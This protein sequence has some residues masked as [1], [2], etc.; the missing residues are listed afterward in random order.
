[1]DA[2]TISERTFRRTSKEK[3]KDQSNSCGGQI[4]ST[5][6]NPRSF[7]YSVGISVKFI[8]VGMSW[9][10]GGRT[11]PVF[12]KEDAGGESGFWKFGT[13][14]EISEKPVGAKITITGTE[15]RLHKPYGITAINLKDAYR[16]PSNKANEIIH[17]DY[18]VC[19]KCCN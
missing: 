8:S 19:R 17:Y 7:S 15:E 5:E 12:D 3:V 16:T 14:Y 10:G 4:P 18:R 1:M 6:Y 9:S 13:A 11:Y 2:G